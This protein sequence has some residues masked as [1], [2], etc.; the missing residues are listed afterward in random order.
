MTAPRLAWGSAA[1]AALVLLA[2]WG[3]SLAGASL[4]ATTLTVLV[5]AIVVGFAGV[6]ALIASRHPGNLIGW[7][8]CGIALAGR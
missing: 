4:E 8:F 2:G 7:L 6:G 3:L 5:G 1:L